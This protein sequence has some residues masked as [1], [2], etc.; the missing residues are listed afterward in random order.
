MARM[1]ALGGSA[2]AINFKLLVVG[3]QPGSEIGQFARDNK[4]DLVVL[5]WHGKWEE[6]RGGA[7]EAIVRRSAC[8]VFLI[9]TT[10][11]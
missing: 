11:S 5:P 4:V 1:V 7:V 3:G 9:C 6:Q 8:P 2:A 10:T